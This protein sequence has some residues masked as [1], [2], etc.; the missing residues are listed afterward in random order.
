[1]DHPFLDNFETYTRERVTQLTQQYLRDNGVSGS[2]LN[3]E[4][5]AVYVESNGRKLAVVRMWNAAEYQV[6]IL[7]IVEDE[8]RRVLCARTSPERVSISYGPCAI[9]LREVFGVDLIASGDAGA[10]QRSTLMPSPTRSPE[11]GGSI[12]QA[13]RSVDDGSRQ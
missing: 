9:K 5:E 10:S 6:V 8:I 4:S 1:M 11:S 12:D 2:P 13:A 7:G 3:L